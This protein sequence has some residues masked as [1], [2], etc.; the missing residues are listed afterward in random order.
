LGRRLQSKLTFSLATEKQFFPG[1]IAAVLS[2]HLYQS[3]IKEKGNGILIFS[4]KYK[5]K[6]QDFLYLSLNYTSID[7]INKR[8]CPEPL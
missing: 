8:L 3:V 7:K 1:K 2:F 6:P 5:V 4:E